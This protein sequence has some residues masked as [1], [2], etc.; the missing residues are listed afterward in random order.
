MSIKLFADRCHSS[1]K[2]GGASKLTDMR[3]Y[4]TGRPVEKEVNLFCCL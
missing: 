3:K 4:N 2:N 1:F